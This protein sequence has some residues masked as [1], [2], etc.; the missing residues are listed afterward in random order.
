MKNQKIK[1][2]IFDLL[3]IQSLI[4]MGQS[5]PNPPVAAVIVSKKKFGQPHYLVGHTSPQGGPHAEIVALRKY[6][7]FIKKP[8]KKNNKKTRKGARL[9]V[10]LEPCNEQGLTPPCSQSLL[11]TPSIEKIIIFAKD[12]SLKKSP[13]EEFNSHHKK[14]FYIHKEGRHQHQNLS[15][16][17]TGFLNRVKK[18]RPRLHLKIA[19][20]RNYSMGIEGKRVLISDRQALSFTH[21]LRAQCDAILF[22]PKTIMTDL[23]RGI[24]RNNRLRN[25]RLKQ[26][27][28]S[29]SLQQDYYLEQ[30]FNHQK[31]LLK[32]IRNNVTAYQPKRIFIIGG[33]GDQPMSI[34]QKSNYRLFF[35]RQAEL[36]K[37]TAKK[38]HYLFLKNCV[39]QWEAVRE[40]GWPVPIDI[41]P[42]LE[43]EDFGQSL[44]KH[45]CRLSCNEVLI[46]GGAGLLAS[47]NKTIGKD[48][49]I[50]LLQSSEEITPMIE[51]E[52]LVTLPA[53]LK[54]IAY[55]I[56]QNL[57]KDTLKVAILDKNLKST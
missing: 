9:Y 20:D 40:D 38:S 19:V 33:G 47:L 1:E 48:D 5:A 50:Y 11:R 35:S 34:E 54:T 56:R 51:G 22:G 46:E 2:K 23:P 14:A 49:R 57:G 42:N 52:K 8:K 6:E 26:R 53:Y 18:S 32:T 27:N 45:L 36:D 15:V 39:K 16:F 44:I 10:T 29:P 30:L 41:L 25:L 3:A 24:L 37:L 55:P 4:A 28:L 12:P 7:K 31:F 17:L 13:I 43:Q 21:I